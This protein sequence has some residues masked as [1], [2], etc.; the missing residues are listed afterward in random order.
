MIRIR[1]T[2]DLD[3]IAELD[4]AE[5]DIPLTEEEL[6]TSNWWLAHMGD[7]VVG[8]AGIQ[9]KYAEGKAFLVRGA[10]L[11]VARGGGLQKRMIRTRVSFAKR[12]GINRCY[13]YVWAGN[14][15]SMRSLIACGF[16]PY[17]L[18]RTAD[19]TYIYL[20]NMPQQTAKAE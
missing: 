12:L 15:A 17:Y 4:R 6:N 2:D 8:F 13:T 19:V 20:Q 3:T 11:P 5:F 16:K 1:Q 9:M 18:N 7:E 10:V 14:F